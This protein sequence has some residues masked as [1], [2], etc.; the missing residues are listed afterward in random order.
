MFDIRFLE[1]P[2]EPWEPGGEALW[3]E[4]TVGDYRERFLAPTGFWPRERYVRQWQE[5]GAR[6][7]AGA[8]RTAFFTT[9]WQ[10]WWTLG[11]AGDEVLV[12]EELL[13][14]ERIAVLGAAPD[15]ERVPYELLEPVQLRNEDGHEISTW[16]VPLADV[17]AFTD[18]QRA[19][20]A[21]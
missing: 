16:R 11:R 10:F 5:A 8:E 1:E 15:P 18:R 12:Q 7:A 6:F 3:G 4:I 2:P 17:I 19:G 13:T 21:T 14:G 20:D 9:A